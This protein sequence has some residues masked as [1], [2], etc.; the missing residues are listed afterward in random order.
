MQGGGYPGGCVVRVR[1]ARK[2][3]WVYSCELCGVNLSAP[4]LFRA[5]ERQQAHEKTLDH[6]FAVAV[7]PIRDFAE[8]YSRAFRRLA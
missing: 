2:A 1:K 3:C 8:A 4:D 5:M 6:K 7:K